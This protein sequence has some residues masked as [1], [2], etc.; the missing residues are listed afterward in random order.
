MRLFIALTSQLIIIFCSLFTQTQAQEIKIMGSRAGI[1][2]VN[3]YFIALTKLVLSRTAH[4]YPN[5]SIKIINLEGV[6]QGRLFRLIEEKFIDIV[7]SG[8]DKSR[9]EFYL[10]IRVPLVKGLLGY[11]ALLV[12]KENVKKFSEIKNEYELKSMIACQG[13]HWP[14]TA[15]LEYNGYTVSRTVHYDAMFKMLEKKR[16]DFFPRALFEGRAE[17]IQLKDKYPNIRLVE[18]TLLQ[19]YLPMYYFVKQDNHALAKRLY[20][21][22]VEV[23]HDGSLLT[24]MESHEL[25]RFIFPIHKWQDATIFRLSNLKVSI[26]T[27]LANKKLWLVLGE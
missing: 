23:M 12:H 22:L 19:Y 20:D 5:D 14:D 2:P 10:P 9:E 7:W 15:I 8:T 21:G 25:T 6:T 1:D 26:E 27:P 18:N 17:L 13:A 4:S 24:L 16:C 11:R 3:S